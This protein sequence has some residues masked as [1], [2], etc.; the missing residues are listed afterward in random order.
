MCGIELFFFRGIDDVKLGGC[1]QYGNLNENID[2]HDSKAIWEKTTSVVPSLKKAKVICEAV[3]LRP[4]R[5]I[6]RVETEVITLA[7]GSKL[8]VIHHYGHGGYGV[9]VSP[10]SKLL[11]TKLFD[12]SPF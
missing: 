5:G 11:F 12:L 10:V 6:I 2:P 1:R 8:P 3:G 9:M 7:D 4:H